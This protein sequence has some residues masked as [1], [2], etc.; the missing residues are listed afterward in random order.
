MAGVTQARW[1]ASIAV[2]SRDE[3]TLLHVP[4][5]VSGGAALDAKKIAFGFSFLFIAEALGY[6]VLHGVWDGSI[7][8][9]RVMWTS[10]P[11]GPRDVLLVSF[12]LCAYGVGLLVA[13]SHHRFQH[14]Q[15]SKNPQRS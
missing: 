1:F 11:Q 13:G 3:F 12:V 4:T 2:R 6:L 15:R 9:L 5:D 14:P 8:E 7:A 10:L